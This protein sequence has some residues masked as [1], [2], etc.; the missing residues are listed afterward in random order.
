MAGSC[1]GPGRW[2]AM[3]QAGPVAIV[4]QR[5]NSGVGGCDR[6]VPFATA[7]A[8]MLIAASTTLSVLPHSPSTATLT[9]GR[10]S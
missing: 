7:L 2:Q 5:A 6:G 9:D 4:E 10:R 1:K 8:R 3:R